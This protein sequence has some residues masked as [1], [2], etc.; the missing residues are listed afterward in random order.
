[1]KVIME[2]YENQKQRFIARVLACGMMCRSSAD[3][4]RLCVITAIE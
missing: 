4:E 2:V 3:R 1:M